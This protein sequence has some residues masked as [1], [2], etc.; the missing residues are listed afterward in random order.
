MS[1]KPKQ[2]TNAKGELM[3]FSVGAVI[4]NDGKYLLIDRDM[5]PFGFA[6]IAGHINEG[7]TP[8]E[9]ILRKV[10]EESGLKV[11]SHSPLFEEEVDWNWCKAK[12]TT[13][14]WYVYKCKVEGEAKNNPEA[15]RSIGWYSPNEIKQLKM[16]PVWKYWFEKLGILNK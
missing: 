10:L 5:E 1:T 11:K 2:T 15:S 14:Y 13:H 12:I 9:A 7:E 3:H 6:G 4:E 16:E 8:E